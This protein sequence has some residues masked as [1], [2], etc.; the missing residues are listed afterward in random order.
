[1]KTVCRLAIFLVV[2]SPFSLAQTKI[3]I[4]AGTP[5]DKALQ[6][7]TSEADAQKRVA[8]LEEFVRSFASNPAAVAYGNWQLAQQYLSEDNAAKALA[9]GDK[10]LAAMPDVL[11]ILVMQADIA[12][13]LKDPAKVVDYAVRGA[14]VIAGVEKRPKPAGVN[15][16]DYAATV[17]QEKA[18]LEPSYRYLQVAAYNAIA[19]DQDARR[20]M[21]EIERY[22]GAF[23][24]SN[25]NEQLATLAV[26]SLQEM[27]DSAGLAAF[28]DRMLAKN[29]KD[30]RL[31][32]VLASAYA[33]DAAHRAKAGAYARQAI[34]L[35]KSK[36]GAD[37]TDRKL[38]GVAHSVLGRVLL[39]ES[40][41]QAAA[42][43]LTTATGLLKDSPGDLAGAWYYLGFAYAK[44]ERATDAVRALTN[45]AQ[46]ESPY[47]QPAQELLS[48]IKAVRR[49]R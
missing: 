47:Q 28:G 25:F 2:F 32:T 12:Q 7:I 17:A 49:R 23:P 31:L 1:M 6:Q 35:Q 20:R 30:I 19:E 37:A 43:E 21:Q 13:K 11:D 5:E 33:N 22:M 15:A 18:A 3:V 24:D 41:F 16:A 26:V 4:P 45:A 10:A 42:A 46:I 39:Q 48:K 14:T 34:E 40:K 36:S 27:K 38:A 44:M 8:M 9:H 29:P